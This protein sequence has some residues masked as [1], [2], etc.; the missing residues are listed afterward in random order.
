MPLVRPRRQCCLEPLYILSLYI[1]IYI[2]IYTY[3]Y[4]YIYT[5]M[6]LM[7]AL[8]LGSLKLVPPGL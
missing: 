2:Y 7:N 5:N 6:K 4:L 1:Y 8:F 3:M